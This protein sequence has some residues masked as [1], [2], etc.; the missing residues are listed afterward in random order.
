MAE[1]PTV[2]RQVAGSSPAVG[3]NEIP[4]QTRWDFF[5]LSIL[6]SM[7]ELAFPHS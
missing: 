4:P 7:L 6:Q 5:Y 2:N 3:A 1:R